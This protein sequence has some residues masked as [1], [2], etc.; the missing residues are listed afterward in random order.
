MVAYP[1]RGAG[2]D[3][4][5]FFFFFFFFLRGGGSLS[6]PGLNIFT[7][8]NMGH[9]HMLHRTGLWTEA[10]VRDSKATE[11]LS[12]K[13]IQQSH[14]HKIPGSSLNKRWYLQVLNYLG[15]KYPLCHGLF[16]FYSHFGLYILLQTEVRFAGVNNL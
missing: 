8:G 2:N 9:D 14:T 3:P 7:V 10:Q 1:D 11:R 13:K 5:L 4:K 16:H 6:P 15:F 12:N